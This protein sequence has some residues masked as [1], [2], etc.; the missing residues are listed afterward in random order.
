MADRVH[1]VIC[2]GRA[3]VDLYG[4]QIGSRLEDMHSFRKY[5]GGSS[6]NI[7]VGMA[8]QG[9]KVAM[10]T[11]VGDEHMGRFVRDQ[12]AVNGVDVDH[13]TTDP[14]RL[15]GLALLGIKDRDTFP[16]IFY[17]ERCAD[18]AI[19]EDDFDEAFIASARA[20]VITGTHFSSAEMDRMSRRAVKFARSSGAKTVLDIDYRPVLW[21][22]TSHGDGESRY[23]AAD[24]VT[25]HLQSI[26]PLFD[27][28]VGTEEEV[29]IAAGPTDTIEALKVL[30]KITDATIVVKRGPLGCAVFQGPI[31]NDI[32]QGISLQGMNV[33]PLNVVGAGDGFM[34]GFMRGWLN[35]ETIEQSCRYANACGALV[36][37]RHGC[38]SAIPTAVELD[39]YLEQDGADKATHTD[40][41]L[42][43]LHR[44]TTREKRWNEI[45]TLAFDH[46]KQF[47]EM[48][49]KCGA[50]I[51]LIPKLKTL[52]AEAVRR[53]TQRAG[54]EGS[55][56]LLVDS[57]FGEHVLEAE[58]GSGLWIGRPVEVPGS[59]P[60]EFEAGNN[61]GLEI[62]K[63]PSEHVVKCL[64][65][66]HPDDEPVLREQ[67]EIRLI[68]LYRACTDTAHELLVEL[69]PPSD[70]PRDE[71]MM[72]TALARI[73]SRGVFPDWWKLPPQ[74]SAAWDQISAVIESNDPYCRGVV[75]LS[76][77]AP[78]SELKEAIQVAAGQEHCKGFAVGRTIFGKSAQ[79]WL[80]GTADDETT[81]ESISGNYLRL[82]DLW[83]ESRTIDSNPVRRT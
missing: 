21:A 42:T 71:E 35:D 78:E 11:R 60:L 82:V 77:D 16:L 53:A 41:W 59:R 74:T 64:V 81:V 49:D 28:I 32:D 50:D 18:M 61:V 44:V 51:N 9:L 25:E 8:R 69:I 13:V 6:A 10:L 38:T 54:L 1:D 58:T 45:Y 17:R 30:R 47:V 29:H 83:R 76:L 68:E 52:I 80:A 66:Y 5:L 20:L 14:E 37:S 46:R 65:L 7:A 34:S 79:Q 63:W 67:Q 4:E 73:Y 19:R 2:I 62:L 33:E 39:Y 70:M 40:P 31:P 15:T 23:V 55:A 3:A 57:R 56:G 36:A 43:H 72:A 22:L 26:V 24:R 12:L 48:A 27:L 75:V